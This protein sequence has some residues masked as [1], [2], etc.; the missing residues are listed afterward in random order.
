MHQFLG[1]GS[2]TGSC[3]ADQAGAELDQI[4][5]L[6][7]ALASAL[8]V[9]TCLKPE[10]LLMLELYDAS[11]KGKTITVSVLGLP[12]G[13]APTTTLRYLEMLQKRGFVRRVAHETDS[14]MTYVELTN[15]AKAAMDAAF[16]GG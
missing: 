15:P 2:S 13:I 5:E 8:G 1:S 4:R 9:N 12:N 6:D 3:H 10:V 16:E 11:R 7:A 14:R